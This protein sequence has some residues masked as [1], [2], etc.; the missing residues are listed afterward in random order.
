MRHGFQQ[1]IIN[2]SEPEHHPQT[3]TAG[4]QRFEL[5]KQVQIGMAAMDEKQARVKQEKEGALQQQAVAIAFEA[6]A[7]FYRVLG[8][9]SQVKPGGHITYVQAYV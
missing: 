3:C 5:G 8:A 4:S 9:L 2:S 1:A 7:I 6:I